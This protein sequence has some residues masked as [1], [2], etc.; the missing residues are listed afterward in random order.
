MEGDVGNGS[1]S[2]EN[3]TPVTDGYYYLRA[4]SAHDFNDLMGTQY[5][6]HFLVM[7]TDNRNTTGILN[8]N[9]TSSGKL[10]ANGDTDWIRVDVEAG[11]DINSP[12]I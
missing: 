4:Q 10:D 2:L 11:K 6:P 1:L 12:L 5:P 3:I 9:S 7:I 8:L